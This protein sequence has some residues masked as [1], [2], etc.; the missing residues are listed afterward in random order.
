MVILFTGKVT[1][2]VYMWLCMCFAQSVSKERT[3][4]SCVFARLRKKA[5]S[6]LVITSWIIYHYD[7]FIFPCLLR[8]FCHKYFVIFLSLFQFGKLFF[9]KRNNLIYSW[10]MN[11][12][13]VLCIILER[14]PAKTLWYYLD[15]SIYL[16][17]NLA[18]IHI[19][20]LQTKTIQTKII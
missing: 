15:Y 14:I 7:F 9:F 19:P 16:A 1:Q 8:C 20:S 3:F 11:R 10:A 2:T 5:F 12:K 18:L 6:N 17:S 13:S 4:K